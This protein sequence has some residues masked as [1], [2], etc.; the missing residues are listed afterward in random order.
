MYLLRHSERKMI[1]TANNIEAFL[2]HNFWSPKIKNKMS[3]TKKIDYN[4]DPDPV[5]WITSDPY[6]LMPRILIKNPSTIC[7]YRTLLV[8]KYTYR[9][10]LKYEYLILFFFFNIKYHVILK[11]KKYKN[12]ILLGWIRIQFFTRVGSGSGF[13]W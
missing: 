4:P 6:F 10:M 9:I 3:I 12:I 5:I 8:W 2:L 11:A 13:S 7:N 1:K